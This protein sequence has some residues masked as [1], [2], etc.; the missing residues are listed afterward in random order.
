[1]LALVL[2]ALF[3][4]LLALVVPVGKAVGHAFLLFLP[5]FWLA[6]LIVAFYLGRMTRRFNFLNS[7]EIEPTFVVSRARV[8]ARDTESW[9]YWS[10]WIREAFMCLVVWLLIGTAA[11]SPLL[12]VFVG[13]LEK[14]FVGN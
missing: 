4:V 7:T 6:R 1:M 2:T 11:L 5:N 10:N 8:L 9:A 3:T 14:V 12:E 13:P